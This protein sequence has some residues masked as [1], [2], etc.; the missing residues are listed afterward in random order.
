[1]N[2]SHASL[3]KLYECSHPYINELVQIAIESGA[4]GARLTGAGSV[5]VFVT[6]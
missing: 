6:I 3:N 1:M 2:K 5:F 4:Y